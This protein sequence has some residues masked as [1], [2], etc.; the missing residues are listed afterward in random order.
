MT[1]VLTMP[2]AM[3]VGV[4]GINKQAATV[5]SFNANPFGLYDMSGNVWEWT[6]S[7]WREQFDGSEQQCND[8]ATDTQ[9]RVL[10]GGSW[11]NHPDDVR[12]SVRN[13][14]HP[15]GRSFDV[16]FRELCSSPNRIA[17]H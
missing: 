17:V 8:D 13:Y 16:G 9:S 7:N 4:H 15:A 3:D 14:F 2:I 6:C 12:A 11:D 5:G 10:R 1:L